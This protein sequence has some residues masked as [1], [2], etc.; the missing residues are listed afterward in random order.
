M[1]CRG[2]Q[3]YGPQGY[4]NILSQQGRHGVNF[5]YQIH[6]I[7]KPKL[8]KNIK[9]WENR[10]ELFESGEKSAAKGPQNRLSGRIT[11]MFLVHGVIHSASYEAPVATKYFVN[12]QLKSVIKQC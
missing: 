9:N 5:G 1:S 6:L 12:P 11:P 7:P 3:M 10:S 2:R 4:D 8:I